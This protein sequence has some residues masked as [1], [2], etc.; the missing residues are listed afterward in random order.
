MSDPSNSDPTNT[1]PEPERQTEPQDARNR[2]LP[3]LPH[4]RDESHDSQESTPRDVMLQAKKDVDS[5]QEDT[6]LRGTQG[7][8]NL[9]VPPSVGTPAA[10]KHEKETPLSPPVASV[11]P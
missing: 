6:D 9:G 4:E 11:N 5:G 7:H 1:L 2:A 3:K 8:R 10:D